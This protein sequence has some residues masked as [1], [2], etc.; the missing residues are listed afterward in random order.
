MCPA[1]R[2][3]G[4]C[5]KI[6]AICPSPYAQEDFEGAIL[7][8]EEIELLEAAIQVVSNVVP[9]ITIEMDVFVS[10]YIREISI[11]MSVIIR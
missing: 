7:L 8:F 3:G 2:S 10:P 11:Y 9:R 1:G 6:R 4:W 5:C